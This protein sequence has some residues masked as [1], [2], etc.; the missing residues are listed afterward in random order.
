[1]VPLNRLSYEIEALLLKI[2]INDLHSSSLRYSF[3]FADETTWLH[4]HSDFPTLIEQV[5]E[6]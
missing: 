3:L 6:E 1:M 2:Y 4:S 5:N